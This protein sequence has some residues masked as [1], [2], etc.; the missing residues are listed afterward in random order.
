VQLERILA[1][2]SAL[3]CGTWLAPDAPHGCNQA[4]QGCEVASPIVN[5]KIRER[6]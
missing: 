4:D 2:S 5:V 1:E 6:R 3:L